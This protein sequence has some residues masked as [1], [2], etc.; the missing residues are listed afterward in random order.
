MEI[1]KTFLFITPD[2][3][4]IQI[5]AAITKHPERL[6][7]FH[8][9]ELVNGAEAFTEEQIL[10]KKTSHCLV[11]W[12][13]AM[14]PRAAHFEMSQY[15]NHTADDFAN[16]ILKMNGRKPIPMGI[17]HS[18]EESMLKVIKMRATE[19]RVSAAMAGSTFNKYN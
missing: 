7:A 4:F 17:I 18:D 19:E 15:P 5:E 2:D 16:R 1:P 8:F 14:T 6:K 3:L 12:I 9:H 10:D 13:I 11:G